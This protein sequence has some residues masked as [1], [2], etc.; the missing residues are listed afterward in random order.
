[1]RSSE[2]GAD[3]VRGILY[4]VDGPRPVELHGLE[5]LVFEDLSLQEARLLM[6][7]PAVRSPGLPPATATVRGR[8]FNCH[9]DNR[10]LIHNSWGITDVHVAARCHLVTMLLPAD[11]LETLE[12]G[13]HSCA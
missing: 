3:T 8:V 1:L 7:V 11:D 12:R 2:Q 9:E 13:E 6:L 4:Y 10:V 5:R